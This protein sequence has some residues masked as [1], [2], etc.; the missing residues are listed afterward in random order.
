MKAF[1]V[2]TLPILFYDKLVINNERSLLKMK[3]K[4]QEITNIILADLK[5][6]IMPITPLVFIGSVTMAF[7]SI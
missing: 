5:S 3:E 7:K 4:A 6:R 1:L 2:K